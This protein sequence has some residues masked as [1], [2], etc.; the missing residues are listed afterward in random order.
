MLPS[1]AALFEQGTMVLRMAVVPQAS[2]L[3]FKSMKHCSQGG[4]SCVNNENTGNH[5]TLL[6]REQHLCQKCE[7][8]QL[9]FDFLN[10]DSTKIS[11]WVSLIKRNDLHGEARGHQ[12]EVSLADGKF[13]DHS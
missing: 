4:S 1:L 6:S 7:H 9:H 13:Y 10:T 5:E 11:T 2:S 3:L 8:W 12:Q